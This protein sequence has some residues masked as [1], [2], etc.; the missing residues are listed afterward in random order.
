MTRNGTAVSGVAERASLYRTEVLPRFLSDVEPDLDELPEASPE[1]SLELF[2]RLYGFR[3]QGAPSKAYGENA[4]AALETAT[5]GQTVDVERLWQRF[6][7]RCREEGVGIHPTCTPGVVKGAAGLLNRE[8]NLFRWVGSEVRDHGRLSVPR[9]ELR[10]IDG[11][12]PKIARFFLRDAVQ[13][14]DVE[15]DVR[16]GD[17]HLL[18]SLTG[19]VEMVAD[20]LWPGLE[21]ADEGRTVERIVAACA[22]RGVSGVEFNQGAW[23]LAREEAEGDSEVVD[24]IIEQMRQSPPT[25]TE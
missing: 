16:P 9:D 2:Y 20:A 5:D 18:Q 1:E 17:R 22:D 25:S 10:S 19:P 12:G 13:F 8:G 23:Y 21:D 15:D 14:C 4:T 7:A 11:I 3:R 6:E 24:E